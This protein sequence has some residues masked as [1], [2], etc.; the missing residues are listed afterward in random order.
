MAE[1]EPTRSTKRDYIILRTTKPG[2][3]EYVA[4]INHDCPENAY[5][6]LDEADRTGTLHAIPVR[7]WS[8]Q[9]VEIEQPPPVLTFADGYKPGDDIAAFTAEPV[10]EDA[11]TD[12][13]LQPDV[14]VDEVAAA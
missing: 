14:E 13:A 8:T 2:V 6:T 1:S 4:T 11:P 10:E 7:Y 12:T 5:K 9:K 3:Y